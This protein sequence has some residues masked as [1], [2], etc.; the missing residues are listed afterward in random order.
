MSRR[1]RRARRHGTFTLGLAITV[2]IVGVAAL[3]L[4]YTPWDPLQMNIVGRLEALGIPTLVLVIDGGDGLAPDSAA[5]P[6][7]PDGAAAVHWLQVGRI[8]E[9]LQRL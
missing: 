8:A 3:S 1:W 5:V 9:G 7:R 2:G 4:V 6:T